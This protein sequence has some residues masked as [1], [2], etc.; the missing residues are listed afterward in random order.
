MLLNKKNPEKIRIKNKKRSMVT[1]ERVK[2]A[3]LSPDL[4][5]LKSKIEEEW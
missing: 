4:E 2:S 3:H 1:T 5:S